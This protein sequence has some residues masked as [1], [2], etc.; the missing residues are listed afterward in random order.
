MQLEK[1]L[2]VVLDPPSNRADDLAKPRDQMLGDYQ[3]RPYDENVVGNYRELLVVKGDIV[4]SIW[5]RGRPRM[6]WSD[7]MLKKL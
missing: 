5:Q 1:R 6:L 3:V 4:K 2:D 7:W